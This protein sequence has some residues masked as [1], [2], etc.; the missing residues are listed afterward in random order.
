MAYEEIP[1]AGGHDSRPVRIGATVHRPMKS[2]SA[3]IHA[4]LQHFERI[5]FEGAPRL[6]GIDTSGRE[7]LA[8]VPGDDGRVARCYDDEALIA[9]GQLIRDCHDAIASFDPPPGSSWHVEPGA[10]PGNF[11]CHNDLSPANTIYSTGRP[12]A[13]IDWDLATRSTTLWDL[14]YAARTFI[15]LYDPEDCEQFGYPSGRQRQRLKLFCDSYRMD[16]QTRHDLLSA[17]GHRLSTETSAFARRCEDALAS[18]WS[19]WAAAIR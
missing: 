9:V 1:L 7:I 2:W 3:S 19:S 6:L 10:P 18:N 15:P 13:F 4:L 14:S 8:Y 5:G 16:R 12:R 11:I 17:V